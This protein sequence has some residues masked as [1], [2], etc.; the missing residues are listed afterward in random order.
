MCSGSIDGVLEESRE[1]SV[2]GKEIELDRQIT[3]ADY[4]T[5]L[6][7][8][9]GLGHP[10]S[11]PSTSTTTARTKLKFTPPTLRKLPG[12]SVEQKGIPLQPV[13]LAP[14]I[15]ITART[16]QVSPEKATAPTYWTAN[17][18]VSSNSPSY[19]IAYY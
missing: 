1:Y 11:T 5:G 3:K 12:Q 15:N 7:F 6:C 9:N 18:S 4:N 19:P 8:G 10:I 2:G 17:W 16:A 13:D 14:S